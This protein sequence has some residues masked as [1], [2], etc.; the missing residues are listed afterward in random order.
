MEMDVLDRGLIPFVRIPA[1]PS[2]EEARLN[3]LHTGGTLYL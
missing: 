3:L 2:A 1:K